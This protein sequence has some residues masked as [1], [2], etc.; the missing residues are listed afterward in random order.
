MPKERISILNFLR[1]SEIFLQEHDNN[2]SPSEQTML[3]AMLRRLSA[4]VNPPNETE[5][6]Q[7]G[8]RSD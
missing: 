3:R 6:P 7:V 1:A 8:Q 5:D 2:Y 4:K